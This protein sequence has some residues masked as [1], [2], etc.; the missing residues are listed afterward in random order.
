[1][2]A[3]PG[4]MTREVVVFVGAR[5]WG[6]A[7]GFADGVGQGDQVV[8]R[9]G[10]G[11]EVTVVAD[12]VPASGGGEAAGVRLAEVV[13]VRLREGGQR[14]DHG[15]GIAVHISQRGYRLPG[16]AIAGAAPWGPHGG[17]LFPRLADALATRRPAMHHD[18]AMEIRHAAP[19]GR[20]R[21]GKRGRYLG[22]TPEA[23]GGLGLPT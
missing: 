18:S 7:A 1:M 19:L 9:G 22:N 4:L 16:T 8:G 15:G 13:R 2:A 6:R 3:P 5:R 21:A 12:Q 17:T 23:G 20:I 11:R 14:A 10:W